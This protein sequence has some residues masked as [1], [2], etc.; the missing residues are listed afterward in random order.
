MQK[1]G[2]RATLKA[3]IFRKGDPS[4]LNNY[5]Y[6]IMLAKERNISTAAEKLFISHQCLSKYLK[7]LEKHYGI[8]LF[9]R[10]PTFQLTPAGQRLLKTYKEIEFEE[11]NVE[12]EL[13]DLKHAETGTVHFGITEGRYSIVVPR[14][15][16]QFY[17][18]YPHV[19]VVITNT[20]SP[21]MEQ[22]IMDNELDLFLSG[23]NSVNPRSDFMKIMDEHLYLVISDNLLKKYFP[24]EPDFKE[25]NKDG[26]D[27]LQFSS[28]PCFLNKP[29]FNTR[30]VI[31]HYLAKIG[32]TLNCLTELT[33]LDMQYRLAA[34]DMGFSFCLTMYLEG[35]GRIN[36]LKRFQGDPNMLNVFPIKGLTE[37]NPLGLIFKR[38]RIFP[39]YTQKFCKTVKEVCL[40]KGRLEA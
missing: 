3:S 26:I 38:G 24:E 16:K 8:T 34:E 30:S 17:Q 7:N 5:Q 2:I 36:Q 23:L 14:L 29:N 35:I 18:L 22:M 11:Q 31:D 6:F 12:A 13:A 25:K 21:K 40:E 37:T 19:K 1:K 15:L 39:S 9:E 10:K 4:M 33:Q 27:L 20:T 32:G 28:I